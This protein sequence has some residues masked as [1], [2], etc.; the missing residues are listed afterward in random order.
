MIRLALALPLAVF[1]DLC[2]FGMV[3]VAFQLRAEAL[4]PPSLKAYTGPLVG[5][6]LALSFVIQLAVSPRWGRLADRIGP[7]P[8]FLATTALSAS[9]AAAFGLAGS[10]PLLALSRVLAGLGSANTAVAQAWA[11]GGGEEGRAGRMGRMSAAV[12]AGLVAGAGVGGWLADR[13]GV[14]WVGMVGAALSGFGL[15]VA[16]F[17]PGP[18]PTGGAADATD[19]RRSLDLLRGRPTL[20]RLVGVAIVAWFSL[21]MLEGTF[22]RLIARLYDLGSREFGWIFSYESALGVL[23]GALFVERLARRASPGTILRGGYLAQ[24]IGLGLNPLAGAFGQP[25]AGLF[26]ASTLYAVGA[27]VSNPVV[28]SEAAALVPEERRGELFGLL[29]GARA[30]GFVLGPVIGGAVFDRVPWGPYALAAAVCGLAALAVP[31]RRAA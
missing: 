22:A 2:G 13:H 30:V 28:N 17:L 14:L 7:R 3:L 16:T 5:S 27:G 21:A 18:A 10:L 12:N 23:V 9:A 24:G 15:L 4:V 29:Q 31:A 26:L 20:V 8:V 19:S 25:L 11:S 6:L 1:L